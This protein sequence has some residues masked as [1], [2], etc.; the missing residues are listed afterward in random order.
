MTLRIRK[1]GSL[2]FQ[3]VNKN[4]VDMVVH[5]VVKN[6][7]FVVNLELED[8]NKR[9]FSGLDVKLL[10]QSSMEEVSLPKSHAVE[11]TTLQVEDQKASLEVRF[12][13]PSFVLATRRVSSRLQ[14]CI[15]DLIA[16]SLCVNNF[17]RPLG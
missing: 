14:C 11:F 4:G 7:P 12:A 17:L 3:D 8:H 16:W 15:F 5:W 6:S 1:V 9:G 10:Y 2:F 13:V